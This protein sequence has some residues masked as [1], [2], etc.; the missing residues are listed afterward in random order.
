MTVLID[1]I[2]LLFSTVWN[3]FSVPWPGF[4]FTIGQAHLATLASVGA[5]TMITKMN[6]VSITG[7]FRGFSSKGG[8]NRN[9]KISDARRG[10]TK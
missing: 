10:D 2:K 5:L 8:N 1:F 7:T 9:I 4:Q 6:G 3:M